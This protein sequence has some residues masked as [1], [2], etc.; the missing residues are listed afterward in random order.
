[1][2]K[3]EWRK[4]NFS[5]KTKLN[6]LERLA[7]DKGKSIFKNYSKLVGHW[8]FMPVI[9]ATQEADIKSTAVRSQLSK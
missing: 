9:L 6:Y 7:F 2:I 5:M 3:Y 8:W 1:M 4:N